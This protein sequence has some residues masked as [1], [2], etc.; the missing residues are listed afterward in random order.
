MTG[1]SSTHQS[2]VW[3]TLKDG[4]RMHIRRVAPDRKNLG[5]LVFLHGASVHSGFYL[6]SAEK[7]ADCG[8]EVFLP[9]M[10]GHGES[11]GEPGHVSHK[12]QYTD[13]FVHFVTDL[14]DRDQKPMIL[15][16]HSSGANIILKAVDRLPEGSVSGVFMVA[17]TFAGDDRFMRDH[18]PL[19]AAVYRLSY[20]MRYFLPLARKESDKTRRAINFSFLHFVLGLA[21]LGG[22]KRVLSFR[23]FRKADAFTYTTAAASS[24]MAFDFDR[25]AENLRVPVLL[26]VGERD[27]FVRS[28]SLALALRWS[29]P[30]H[31]L[32]EI[33]VSKVAGHFSALN[34]A[35]DPLHK[36]V[37]Q[38]GDIIG[39]AHVGRDA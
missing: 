5:R 4:V 29:L 26:V 16:G 30:P 24:F 23:P 39:G 22:K 10:R 2:S 8:L 15:G 3:F 31:I 28:R 35:I 34:Y 20:R 33:V 9:D 25:R 7:Y 17:P 32:V 37:A 21:G 19:L 38:C 13:D 36:W 11:E 27:K 6:T 14:F 1:A 12:D 18:N